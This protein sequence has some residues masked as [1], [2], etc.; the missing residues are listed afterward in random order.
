MTK[1]AYFNYY[2]INYRNSLVENK[3]NSFSLFC[4]FILNKQFIKLSV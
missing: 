2:G 1:C 3:I 4:T